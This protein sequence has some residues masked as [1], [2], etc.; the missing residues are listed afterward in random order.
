MKTGQFPW[1]RSA[2]LAGTILSLGAG[3]ARAQETGAT[4]EDGATVEIV[5]VGVRGSLAA[6]RDLRRD[7]V[8]VVD[9]IVAEDIAQF[10]QKNMAEALQR[11]SGVQIRRDFAGGVGNEIS[12]R[13]LPPEYTSVTINGLPATSNAES[14]TFNFN[15]LPAELFRRVEVFKSPIASMDEGG[16]GGTIALET[17]R[18]AD[19]GDRRGVLSFE[20]NSNRITEETTP[21]VTGLYALPLGDRGGIVFGAAYSEFA[22]ASQSY[23]SVRWTRRNFTLGADTYAN[24]FLM[25]LPRYI[26]E[27]QDVER[28]SLT[29]SGQFQ[30]SDNFEILGDVFYVDNFQDQVRYTPIWFFNGGAGLSSITVNGGAVEAAEFSSVRLALED[31]F[32]TNQTDSINANMRG[33]YTSDRLTVTGVAAFSQ[34]MRDLEELRYFSDVRA[35]AGYDIRNDDDYFT[36]TTQVDLSNPTLF[37]TVEARRTI[38]EVE[39]QET[40][41]GVDSEWA[42]TGALELSTGLR[43]RDRTLE[44]QRFATNRR[45]INQPFSPVAKLFTGFLEDEGRAPGPSAFAVHDRDAAFAAYGAALNPRATPE[46]NNFYDV[47]EAVLAGYVMADWDA[48]PWRANAGVR[49]A[50]TEVTSTGIERNRTL[51]TNVTREVT[52]E[53]TDVLPSVS[54]RYEALPDVFVRFAAARV[55]TRPNLTDLAAYREI[56]DTALTITESNPDLEPFRANQFDLALEWYFGE[57]GLL[58][59]GLFYKD[60][61]S[62]IARRSFT[63]TLGGVD[64]RLT[65]PVNSNEATIEGFEVNYQ[66]AFTFLP[67]PFNGF[68]FAA[69]Y[70]YTDS[71]FTDTISGTNISYGL[72]NS[73]QDTYNLVGYYE[74]ERFSARLAYNFRGAFLRE[75]PNEQDGL[76]YRDDFG[77]L[78]FSLRWNVVP[79]LRATFDVLNLMDD[80]QEEY[81]FEDRL[82][83]GTFTTGRT[84]Q[85]GLRANF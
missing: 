39:D 73:S 9:A 77:Q 53:Y 66:Q 34:T 56:N 50:R 75:I 13:G 51:N 74:N 17:V 85:V 43:Y 20:A 15:V 40:T 68:G 54:A 71:S 24:V 12:I 21:R 60:V 6:A 1:S 80:V 5:V 69:N 35:R 37:T 8:R 3:A 7:D 11:V 27:Q 22:A 18:P 46:V 14:R 48:G 45:N 52:S 76:K 28:L 63:E 49:V 42:A 57:D 41:I 84:F 30:V 26:H 79:D 44:R 2:L 78:D 59:V 36:I 25:D 10:P 29:A 61:E 33:V 19:F 58:A 81:V 38:V 62:F 31:N 82:T 4:S 65:R 55:M 64:Y 16:I 70:T 47:G 83:D 32:Q 72:P 23:D 67:A